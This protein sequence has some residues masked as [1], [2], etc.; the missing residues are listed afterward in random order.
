MTSKYQSPEVH[1]HDFKSSSS[2]LILNDN[3]IV[4]EKN[5]SDNTQQMIEDSMKGTN[6]DTDENNN[7]H[8]RNVSMIERMKSIGK[9]LQQN[10][11]DIF[12][13][14]EELN[15]KLEDSMSI[16]S[17]EEDIPSHL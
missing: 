16:I 14:D 2:D 3:E 17:D 4:N 12:K 9:I 11:V 7:N 13:N 1:L 6:F 8:K 10:T 5:I 15:D